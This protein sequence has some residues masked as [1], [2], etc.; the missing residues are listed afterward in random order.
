MAVRVKTTD[1]IWWGLFSAGG[2]LAAFLFPVH[3]MVTGVGIAFGWVSP[4]VLSYPRMIALLENPL[5]QIYVF[6]LISL[7]LFHWAHRFRFVLMDLGLRNLKTPVAVL[8]YGVAMVGT[9]LAALLLF[10]FF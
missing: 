6:L 10:L 9:L 3:V 5:L 2:T 8:C 7:P 1:P 4:Q